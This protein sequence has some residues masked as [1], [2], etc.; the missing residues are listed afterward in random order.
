MLPA[1]RAGAR[2][3]RSSSRTP[4]IELGFPEDQIEIAES[5]SEAVTLALLSTPEEGQV[6]ISGSLYVVGAARSILVKH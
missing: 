1:A 2:W 3:T 4:R 6:V 5:V